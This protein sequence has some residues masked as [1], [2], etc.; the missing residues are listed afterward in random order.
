M[1]AR[2]SQE[3]L[4]RATDELAAHRWMAVLYRLDRLGPRVQADDPALQAKLTT[5][6]LTGKEL[7]AIQS[8]HPAT[9]EAARSRAL[10]PFRRRLTSTSIRSKSSGIFTQ[11]SVNPQRRI[12]TLLKCL[13]R[14]IDNHMANWKVIALVNGDIW[15][16]IR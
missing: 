1:K 16:W 2:D 12:P 13:V 14:N 10:L 11:S 3:G 5:A 8:G 6:T 9:L 15:R 7:D 4:D